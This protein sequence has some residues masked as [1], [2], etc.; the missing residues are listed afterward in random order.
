VPV[1]PEGVAETAVETAA[2]ET[3]EERKGVAKEV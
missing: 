3:A 2:V 1:V